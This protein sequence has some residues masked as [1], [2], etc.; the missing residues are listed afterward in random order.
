MR[1]IKQWK[2]YRIVEREDLC[3][4]IDDL[5]GDCYNAEVNTDIPPLTLARQEK[6]F[7]YRVHA[8]GVYGYVLEK[9]NPEVGMGWQELDYCWGFV[10]SFNEKENEFNH[11]I[12]EEFISR[13][14][15]DNG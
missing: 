6:E 11:D 12:I 3:Y 4:D 2:V 10:G 9:W 7:E 14:E 1:V 13:T 8:H 5:K 15:D